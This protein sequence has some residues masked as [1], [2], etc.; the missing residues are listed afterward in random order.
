MD[1]IYKLNRN[2]HIRRHSLSNREMDSIIIAPKI[3]T[4]LVEKKWGGW[5]SQAIKKL[6]EYFFSDGHI[7]NTQEQYQKD[8]KEIEYNDNEFIEKSHERLNSLWNYYN[9]Y[10]L[11]ILKDIYEYTK[12]VHDSVVDNKMK[13][14]S[15]EQFHIY[16]TDNFLSLFG[17][18]AEN[19]K[20]RQSLIQKRKE[21]LR[22]EISRLKN[23]VKIKTT[24][25]DKTE[26]IKR[27]LKKYNEY[28]KNIILSNLDKKICFD[29]LYDENTF[30]PYGE[31]DDF[32]T[33]DTQ[34]ELYSGTTTTLSGLE[35]SGTYELKPWVTKLV[36]CVGYN[37]Y[38]SSYS[39]NRNIAIGKNPLTHL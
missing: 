8:E 7:E 34:E 4:D 20:M 37:H 14:Q 19:N 9:E 15:L 39:G 23:D 25:I 11:D 29:S 10:K 5:F 12:I 24:I 31:D 22:F 30:N 1:P 32:N 33:Y 16:Y 13:P 17:K 18:I 26:T 28:T 3:R 35:T 21:K 38:H 6:A 36:D 27:E 2:H